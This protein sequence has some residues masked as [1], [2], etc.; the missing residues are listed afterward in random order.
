[1]DGSSKI[2]FAGQIVSEEEPLAR[3]L[4]QAISP[5]D[6]LARDVTIK[7][8]CVKQDKVLTP[9][10]PDRG[11]VREHIPLQASQKRIS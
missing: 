2:P 9:V 7:L 11:I 3:V 4:T 5:I 6:L 10:S 1:M 8:N